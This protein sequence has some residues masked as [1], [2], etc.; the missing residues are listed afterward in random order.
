MKISKLPNAPQ[1]LIDAD[2]TDADVEWSPSGTLWWNH[3]EFRGGEFWGDKLSRN[4]NTLFGLKWIVTISDTKMQIGCERH[5]FAAWESFNDATINKMG[6][7]ALKFWR[8]YKDVLLKLCAT[9]K[10]AHD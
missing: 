9:R 8:A 5:T 7:G 2:T 3:G 4:P 10:G 6:T 1:W